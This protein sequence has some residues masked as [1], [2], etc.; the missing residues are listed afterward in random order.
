[1]RKFLSN[2][3][4]KSLGF[5]RG[6]GTAWVGRLGGGAAYLPLSVAT[7]RANTAVQACIQTAARAFLEPPLI[8]EQERGGQ[9]EQVPGHPILA[10]LDAT[11]FPDGTAPIDHERRATATVATLLVT[12]NAYWHKLRNA[13]GRVIGFDWL[14]AEQ[15]EPKA[16]TGYPHLLSHYEV[17]RI[18]RA[19]ER[20]EVDDVIHF[21]IG[22]DPHN[23][24]LGLS[25]L[26]S[27]MR[28]ILTDTEAAVYSHAILR[29]MGV[30]AARVGPKASGDVITP[31]QA[32]NLKAK[33][34][35]GFSGDNRGSVLVSSLPLDY[36]RIGFSPAD[37]DVRSM[38]RSPEERISA[39]LGIPAVVAGLGAGLERST[40][41]NMAEA[42]E[43][44]TES[45]L[46]PMWRL[47]AR[48][49]N[50]SLASELAPGQRIAFDLSDVRALQEDETARYKRLT[51]AYR[52]GLITRAE[53]KRELGFDATPQDEVYATDLTIGQIM[54]AGKRAAYGAL[55]SE[56]NAWVELNEPGS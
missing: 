32:E 33:F 35:A 34:E 51:E 54:D 19:S 48:T 55:K 38:R 5:L 49:L 6:D 41:S 18:G 24:L 8:V 21:A 40:F 16:V 28:E 10:A 7:A 27:A 25:P 12:G 11:V 20:L 3:A 23:P 2:W 14:P 22:V 36:E 17:Q 44:F 13:S 50:R 4:A 9:Y 1:M 29:N 42:R 47:F 15:V 31:E 56:K 43:A 30:P 53:A 45:F 52:A 39:V 26:A 37:I 46:V